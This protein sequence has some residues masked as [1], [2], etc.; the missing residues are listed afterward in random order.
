MKPP[1]EPLVQG[2]RYKTAPAG[3]FFYWITLFF[4]FLRVFVYYAYHFHHWQR[5]SLCNKQR[6]MTQNNRPL[7]PHLQIYKLPLTGILSIAHR[8]TGVL[9]ALGLVV[10]VFSF[11]SLLQGAE[12]YSTLQDF[13]RSPLISIFVWCF[14]YALFFH[15]CH[16]IRHLIWD[17]GIGLEQATMDRIA[18]VELVVS[19]V[20]TLIFY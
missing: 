16:G 17:L 1:L 20:L 19:F 15:L 9:I 11:Y 8:I 7:S 12:S 13:L 4:L 18:V 14:I 2:R 3:D 6:I 10:Y 5:R